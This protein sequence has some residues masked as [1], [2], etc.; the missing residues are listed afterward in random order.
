MS[1]DIKLT[2][3]ERERERERE[4]KRKREGGGGG[5]EYFLAFRFTLCETSRKMPCSISIVQKYL[6]S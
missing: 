6:G 2:Q 3:R 1:F 4:R 5:E